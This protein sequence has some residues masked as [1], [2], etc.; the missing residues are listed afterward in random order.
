MYV[1]ISVIDFPLKLW[2]VIS[3]NAAL[4]I[5]FIVDTFQLIF[6]ISTYIFNISIF[7]PFPINL[8]LIFSTSFVVSKIFYNIA[9]GVK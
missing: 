5:D 3:S 9:R 1:L 7:L 4:V 2:E 8:L 6:R